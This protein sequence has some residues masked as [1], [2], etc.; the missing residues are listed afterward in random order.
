MAEDHEIT[1]ELRAAQ[2][3]FDAE[4]KTSY[5]FLVGLSMASAVKGHLDKGR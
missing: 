5:L 2:R 4:K 3:A 1:A